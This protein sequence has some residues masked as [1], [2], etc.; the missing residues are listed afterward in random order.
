MKTN[1]EW[2]LGLMLGLITLLSLQCSG[3]KHSKSS[4]APPP[5]TIE[6]AEAY[7]SNIADQIWFATS[8][9][10]NSSVTIEPRVVGTLGAIHFS[11]GDYISKGERI[12]TI[13]PSQLYTTLY[14]AE[15]D[16]ESAQAQ[17]IE[18]ENN[19]NRAIPL[20]EINAI[21]KSSLDSYAATYI[22]AKSNLKAARERVRS[23]EL[24]LS[25]SYLNSP[26]N[27]LI[28]ESAA[29]LGDYVGP[30]TT[31][32]TLTTISSIDTLKVALSIPLVKYLKY[33][34]HSHNQHDSTL[35]SN[36]TLILPDSTLYSEQG[37]YSYTQSD[38]NAS[39]STVVIVAKIP[40][41]RS[42]LKPNMFARIKANIGEAQS[43]VMIPQQAVTQMQGVSSVW[44]INS[45]STVSYRPVTLGATYGS[46]WQ[47]ESGLASGERVATSGQL[48]LHEGAHV[49]FVTT[50]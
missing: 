17:L 34:P 22:A 45:D 23:A 32:S 21:S 13:D 28:T 43:R 42:L 16:V 12:F 2:F 8:T 7:T 5:L 38:A 50:K 29:N 15:A 41:P 30:G 37:Q 36:I 44:V 48:K 9:L 6:S 24:D 40:N 26:I 35:L 10:P 4:S 25:Y 39:S 47:V 18:A 31:F 3:S 33:L 46:E 1:F 11:G 20:S 14:A 49:R 19:H 27:G